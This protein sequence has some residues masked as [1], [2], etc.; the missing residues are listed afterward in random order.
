MSELNV[1]IATHNGSA[2]LAR[3]LEGY[4]ALDIH[5]TD[6]KLIVVNNASTDQTKAIINRFAPHLNIDTIYE[7]RPGKNHAMNAGLKAIDAEIVVM[8]DDDSIPHPG[9]MQ[10][11][12]Q[13]FTDMPQIDLFGGSIIPLFDE[14]PAPWIMHKQ[15]RFEELYAHRENI[16]SGPI[17]P[18]RIYGPNMAMRASVIRHGLRFDTRIGPDASRMTSY[19]MGSETAFLRAAV[20][21]GFKTGFAPAPTVSHIIRR[22]HIQPDYIDGRA[23]RMGRGTAFKHCEDGTFTLKHRPLPSRAVGRLKRT[24]DTQIKRLRTNFGTDEQRFHARWNANFYRG[25]HDEIAERKA[26]KFR[27]KN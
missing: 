21:A 9:F 14:E 27:P 1:L 10:Q 17:S 5:N 20:Q 8:S 4:A 2:V 23:Y 11:W 3:T 7:P 24:L 15:P 22:A 16:P 26:K 19:A 25:Y 13:A 18:D 12:L 6:Y